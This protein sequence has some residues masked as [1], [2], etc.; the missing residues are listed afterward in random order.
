MLRRN[1]FSRQLCTYK[2]MPFRHSKRFDSVVCTQVYSVRDEHLVLFSLFRIR[3]YLVV[4][5]NIRHKHVEILP[6]RTKSMADD[7]AI[8]FLKISSSQRFLNSG[9]HVFFIHLCSLV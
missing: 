3:F 4:D 9:A 2:Q 6:Y 8:D 5:L 1:F 7:F